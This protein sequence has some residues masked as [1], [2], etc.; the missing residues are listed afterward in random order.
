MRCL[1]FWRVREGW[2][3]SKRGSKVFNAGRPTQGNF[4]TWVILGSLEPRAISFS[5]HTYANT[6]GLDPQF[7]LWEIND[8]KMCGRLLTESVI[9]MLPRDL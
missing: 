4:R 2:R 8:L 9:K 5:Y 3:R 7:L 6:S 1:A